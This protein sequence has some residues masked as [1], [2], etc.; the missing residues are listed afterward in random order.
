M[1]AALSPSC[2]E[3]EP[4]HPTHGRKHKWGRAAREAPRNRAHR[5]LRLQLGDVSGRGWGVRLR[6]AQ[7]GVEHGTPPQLP[8]GIP[9]PAIAANGSH[10]EDDDDED[11][12]E[13]HDAQQVEGDLAEQ[14]DL[15]DMQKSTEEYQEAW[16]TNSGVPDP[17]GAPAHMPQEQPHAGP[18]GAQDPA[19]S[20]QQQQPS[21]SAP[22]PPLFSAAAPP[23]AE[24]RNQSAS[25]AGPPPPSAV[26]SLK[27]T[28]SI[29]E[30]GTPEPGMSEPMHK[31]VRH[32]CKCG[33][34]ECKG[35]GGRAFCNNP[36]QDCG[37]LECKGRNSKRP[38]RTCA[39]A[40]P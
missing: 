33:S 28:F 1:Y 20:Q 31:R 38:D 4:A 27:R 19:P 36:C 9:P 30:N 3:S 7:R 24:L 35:K 10:G 2:R 40:W 16:N 26:G 39:D 17:N 32:C 14:K 23:A 11:D 22:P 8:A 37:K 6:V 34:N 29:V 12:D 18:S 5:G 15:A 21:A 25:A 13:N